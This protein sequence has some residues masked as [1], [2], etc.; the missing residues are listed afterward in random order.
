MKS[1]SG[2]WFCNHCDDVVFMTYEN[3]T[4][5]KNIPCPACGHLAC[6]FVPNKLTRKQLGEKWFTAMRAAID[7]NSTPDMFK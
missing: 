7:E 2:H 4:N 3:S 1:L 6:E 5:D